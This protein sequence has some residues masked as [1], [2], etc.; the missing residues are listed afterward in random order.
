MAPARANYADHKPTAPGQLPDTRSRFRQ[1][2]CGKILEKAT[3]V[4][5]KLA[6]NDRVGEILASQANISPFFTVFL[7]GS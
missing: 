4:Q 7:V 5:E 6:P 1:E 3:S 2:F